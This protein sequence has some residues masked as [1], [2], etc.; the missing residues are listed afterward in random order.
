MTGGTGWYDDQT[1]VCQ[2]DQSRYKTLILTAQADNQYLYS[3]IKLS[4]L[5]E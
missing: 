1:V 4:K 5:D 2:A 3:S